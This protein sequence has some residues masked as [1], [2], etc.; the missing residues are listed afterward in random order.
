MLK[1]HSCLPALLVILTA[2]VA[3]LP[4]NRLSA[5]EE[6]ALALL[7]QMSA[8]IEGLDA[9]M[10]TGDGYTDARLSA[11]LIIETASEITMRVQKS[12]AVRLTNRTSEGA[13][14]IFFGSGLLSIYSGK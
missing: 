8:E 9:F 12:G 5:Q 6:D 3:A 4:A 13:K 14:E 10:L 7:Q 2:L 1:T 11:G